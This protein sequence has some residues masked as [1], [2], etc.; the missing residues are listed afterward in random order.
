MIFFYYKSKSKKI[1]IKKHI[2][3]F[4]LGEGV[5]GGGWSK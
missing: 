5:E 3:F 1:I 2:S 4:I